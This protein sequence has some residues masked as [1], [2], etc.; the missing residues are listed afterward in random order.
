VLVVDLLLEVVEVV[1]LLDVVGVVAV[2]DDLLDLVV[3]TVVVVVVGTLVVDG[4]VVWVT[5][6]NGM[7]FFVVAEDTDDAVVDAAGPSPG[8]VTW[9]RV[10]GATSAAV[11]RTEDAADELV[12]DWAAA[13]PHAARSRA[14]MP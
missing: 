5:G 1:V 13:L 11:E 9:A 2:V 12:S 6:V 10:G 7:S 3:E 4:A 8:I 14:V